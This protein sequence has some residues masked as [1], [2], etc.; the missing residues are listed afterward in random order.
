[1]DFYSLVYSRRQSEYCVVY[2]IDRGGR[3][4]FRPKA[5][6]ITTRNTHIYTAISP[7]SPFTPPPPAPHSQTTLGPATSS[8]SPSRAPAP[9]ARRRNTASLSNTADYHRWSS[10]DLREPTISDRQPSPPS[11]P[12]SLFPKTEKKGKK[13]KRKKREKKRHTCIMSSGAP[14]GSITTKSPGMPMTR[15]HTWTP[16]PSTGCT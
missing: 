4:S 11:L 6:Q 2:S 7:P 10:S 8:R 16:G 13:K 3:V 14:I 5:Q 15:L 1:M 9:V 12:P